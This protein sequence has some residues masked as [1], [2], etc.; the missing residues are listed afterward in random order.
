MAGHAG[1]AS[2]GVLAT[3]PVDRLADVE[4]Q[5]GGRLG[6]AVLDTANGETFGHRADE[7]FPQTCEGRTVPTS[8]PPPQGHSGP[9][10]SAISAGGRQ[11]T[12]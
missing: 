10:L 12:E 7:R 9:S 3:G 1:L 8:G 4:R 11:Q 5:Y 6:V 2:R